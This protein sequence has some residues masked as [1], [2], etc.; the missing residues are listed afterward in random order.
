MITFAVVKGA[1]F[2]W[3]LNVRLSVID[4]EYICSVE[5]ELYLCAVVIKCALVT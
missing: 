5:R 2:M 3:S 1:L 4:Y